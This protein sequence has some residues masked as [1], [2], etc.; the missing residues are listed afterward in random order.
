MRL[1]LSS[2]WRR[3]QMKWLNTLR[4][5]S[6]V[7]VMGV[8]DSDGAPKWQQHALESLEQ[9]GPLPHSRKIDRIFVS[10]PSSSILNG[11]TQEN[12]FWCW[13]Y[14]NL[15]PGQA[16][17]RVTGDGRLEGKRQQS[18]NWILWEAAP[19]PL[20]LSAYDHWDLLPCLKRL[21]IPSYAYHIWLNAV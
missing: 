21:F 14:V 19:P 20:F 16:H 6:R 10:S 11:N 1:Q 7:G 2:K 3:K 8:M 5:R 13:L 18:I 4:R 17:I 9:T 15:T 12:T